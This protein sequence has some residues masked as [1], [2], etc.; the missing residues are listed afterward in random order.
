MKSALL[1]SPSPRL[2]AT[3]PSR[4]SCRTQPAQCFRP[5]PPSGYPCPAWA[6]AVRHLPRRWSPWSLI[7]NPSRDGGCSWHNH[8]MLWGRKLLWVAAALGTGA[9]ACSGDDSVSCGPGTVLEN[10]K[11]VPTMTGGSGG[12]STG[13]GGAGGG[14]ATNCFCTFEAQCGSSGEGYVVDSFSRT[15]ETIGSACTLAESECESFVAS[16]PC[17]QPG[18]NCP[19][20]SS[21]T[22]LTCHQNS[23]SAKCSG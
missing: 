4:T 8:T 20:L 1:V 21:T 5:P 16:L 15:G 23:T 10:G 18:A 14:T 17:Q 9:A 19:C 6:R 7:G 22:K 3:L 11:C 12:A 2:P 13:G